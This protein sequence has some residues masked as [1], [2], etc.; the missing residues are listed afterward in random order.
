[1]HIEIYRKKRGNLETQIKITV[2]GMFHY[3]VYAPNHLGAFSEKITGCKFKKGNL[4][5]NS[6]E[7]ESPGGVTKE[8]H[9]G[10]A[11]IVLYADMQYIQNAI[12]DRAAMVKAW[13][14]HLPCIEKIEFNI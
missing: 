5:S 8:F 13:L 12:E 7:I 6:A 9:F 11:V 1:M 3:G 4:F 10:E 2:D 14:M